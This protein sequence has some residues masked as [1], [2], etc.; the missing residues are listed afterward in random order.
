M[1]TKAFLR[2]TAL[3]WITFLSI[4]CE[5]KTEIEITPEDYHALV[6]KV[7]AIMVNDIF[8]P[9][10]ASRVYVYPNIAAYQALNANSDKYLSLNPQL[11][12]FSNYAALPEPD[13]KTNLRLA[14]LLAYMQVA[15]KLIFSEHIIRSHR[16]SLI[17]I[18]SGQNPE[19]L[20]KAKIYGDKVAENVIAWM[21]KDRYSETRSMPHFDVY[22]DD[23]AYWQPTPPAYMK[24]IEPHWAKIRPMVLDTASQFKPNPPPPFSL[25]KNSKFYKELYEVYELSESIREKG[26]NSPELNIARFWDCNP[27]VSINKGH[28]MFAEKKITPGAHWM[29]ICKIASVQSGADFEFTVFAYTKTSI[30]LFDGFISCWDEKYRSNLV[31]PET[32]IAKHI[33]ETWKPILQTPPFPEYSS[34]HS[35]ISNAA[36]NVLTFIFGEN[37]SFLDNTEIAYN[38]PERNFDSF[39]DAAQEA[40]LSR[41]YGGIH[42]RSA[43]EEGAI[44]GLNVGNY[45][46]SKLQ[47]IK[48]D[49][50][51]EV[52]LTSKE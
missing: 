8:S 41:L 24:G 3:G 46:N 16:D 45:I 40:T 30:A 52:L 27:Y 28:Y 44:Q 5:S 42:Y 26:D 37:F 7:T 32:L 35:V 51:K 9:P 13:D 39:K 17:T 31:R 36:A 4:G 18:W 10:Q 48:N 43:I 21:Q 20:E 50:S 25:E 29:G 38:L 14:A 23:E 47:L 1:I 2:V 11:N 12:E 34:G 15:E 22:N 6:D 19:S 49:I 33:D